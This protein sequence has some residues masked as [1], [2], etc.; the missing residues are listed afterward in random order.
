MKKVLILSVTFVVGIAFA[1]AIA[2]AQQK[3]G[4]FFDKGSPISGWYDQSIA[5]VVGINKYSNG[6]P[7][8]SEPLNDARRVKQAL[9][10]QGF[11]VILLLDNQATKAD[12]LRLIETEIPLKMTSKSRFIF[13][14]C[15]HGQT[16]IAARSGKQLGYLVPVDGKRINGQ[17]DWSSYISMESL[18]SQI[19]NKIPAKH[20]LIVFDSCFSGLALT[21]G[22]DFGGS[23]VDHMLSQPAI[24]VL[25]AGD[26]GQPTPDGA[27]SYDFVNAIKGSA[28]TSPHDGY[29]TFAEIGAYLQ[30]Q[31]PSKTPNLSPTFG[32]W[33]GTS[34]M[35][36][37]YGAF[38]STGP[39]PSAGSQTAAQQSKPD[40]SG[41]DALAQAK[42]Q[43]LSQD[44]ANLEARQNLISEA[45]TKVKG[46]RQAKEYSPETK[47]SMY[48]KF[49][50]DF[51]N[52]TENP[53]YIEVEKWLNG[54]EP[55]NEM[56]LI[57]AGWFAM[58]CAADDNECGSDE[59]PGKRIYVDSFYMDIHE[60]TVSEYA[61]CVK[62]GACREPKN[63]DENKYCNWGYP[64]RG[65]YPANCVPWRQAWD[66]CAWSG[67]RLPTEAEWEYAARGSDARIY[68]WGNERGSCAN[69]VIFEGEN[70]CGRD[71]AWPVMSKPKGKSPFG[72][73]DMAG[74]LWEWCQDWYDETWYSRMPE[75]NPVNQNNYT[76]RVIR[77]GSW[78]T[79]FRF[80]RS[81]N[82]DR[83][84]P[85]EQD[86]S[87]G[88][89]C[90]RSAE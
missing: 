49:L 63:K 4:G 22:G 53:Y 88:F 9:E 70:G 5:L 69:A 20:A 90:V 41:Y 61:D 83:L 7:S 32:W 18:R 23:N 74:N 25:T 45:Y 12:I 36:F 37:R 56:V 31:I 62:T 86:P 76:R 72:L 15:G 60:V 85:S 71:S 46:Y 24:N 44:K 1:L 40:L 34:Q 64:N 50:S 42:E 79:D 21:K 80:I 52:R 67:K 73:Y 30:Q 29:V 16:E 2:F 43:S 33:D 38:A 48:Q 19:S 57:P 27:F 75:K 13:Y 3:G 8:L 78:N 87:V 10:S 81:S 68:P 66:Y 54:T 51:P 6:W 84:D 39:T 59:K 28:D 17:D 11:Q 65:D 47:R 82:R 14:F 35:I 58:G 26:A 55:A 89:R 77:G